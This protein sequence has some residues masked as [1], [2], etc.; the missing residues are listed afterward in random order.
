M[1][2]NS[3]D[4]WLNTLSS[5]LDHAETMGMND[6]E[7]AKSATQLGNFLA[8]NV[9]PDIPENR[10]LKNLWEQGNE[11]ERQALASMLVKM[12]KNH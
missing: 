5:A 3:F 7:I 6:N 11:K 10:L 12:V 4:Q 2:I 9:E 8:T 1:E